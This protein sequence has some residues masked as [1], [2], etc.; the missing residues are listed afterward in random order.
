MRQTRLEIRFPRLVLRFS[1]PGE[2]SRREEIKIDEVKHQT[3]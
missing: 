3:G 1:L 2:I